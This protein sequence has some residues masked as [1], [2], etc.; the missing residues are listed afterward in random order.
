MAE[1]ILIDFQV[2][3]E[4][5][6]STIDLLERTGQIDAKLAS[7]FK[8]STAEFNKQSATIKAVGANL[9]ASKKGLEDVAKASK[10]LSATFAQGFQEGVIDTL[11]EAGVSVEQFN[12]AIQDGGAKTKA[13]TGTVKQE[14]RELTEQI[15]RA[16]ANGQD[17]GAQYDELV[18]KAG[19]LR[20]AIGDVNQE[21]RNTASDTSTFDGLISGA[22]GVAGGFAIAQGATALFGDESEE[23][24]QTL[25]KVN[26]VMAILQGLQSVQNVLQKESALN[27]LLNNK[28]AIVANAQLALENGLQSKNIVVKGLATVAQKAL[29]AAMAA[30][31]I[32]IVVVALAGLI[33]MLDSYA[34]N[35][36]E[37][38]EETARLNA[39][40]ASSGDNLDAELAGMKRNSDRRISDLKAQGAR[41]SEVIK[42]QINNEKLANEARRREIQNL[43]NVRNNLRNAEPE[44]VEKIEAQITKLEQ[45]EL[46]Y[47][48][49]QYIKSNELRQK[50][51][52]ED[53][54]SEEKA[55]EDAIKAMQKVREARD[56]ILR[57]EIAAI[58]RK[59]LTVEEGSRAELTLQ[60]RL[61]AA[62]ADLDL[63]AEK[64]TQNEILLIKEKSLDDQLKLS[65]EYNAKI[66][67]EAI[68]NE[69]SRN[70]AV[71]E[72]KKTSD[73][74]RLILT[75]ANI[76]FTADLEVEA[77][78]GNEA[79][80]KEIYARRDSAIADLKKKFIDDALN[81]ELARTE[82]QQGSIRRGLERIADD[83]KK[84]V[85][86]RTSA[87]NQLAEI[88]VAGVDKQLAA[89]EKSYAQRLIADKDYELQRD[90]LLDKRL[91]AN[92]KAEKRITD[93]NAEENEKRKQKNKEAIEQIL[94]VAQEVGSILQGLS[95]LQTAQ[96][97]S[98]IDKEKQA[99]EE[100]REAGA[101]TEKEAITRA[102]RI[103]AEER[104]IKTEA[105]RREKNLSI[106]NAVINGAGAV[107]KA[108]ATG[109]P[110]LAAIV[111]A[112]AAAQIAIIA[113]RPIP[114][115]GKGKRNKYQGLAEVGETGTEL[116]ERNGKMYVADKRTIM[117]LQK[118]DVVYN[119]KET[120]AM[121]S[122][123]T[124]RV[125]K[126][127]MVTS[128]KSSAVTFDY[129]KLGKSIAKNSKGVH[130]E[131]TKDFVSESVADGL[132]RVN[133]FNNRY[134]FR[135]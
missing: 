42:E 103:E 9:S 96:A 108:L 135:R 33:V 10:S 116:I 15:A 22:Q 44:E 51:R 101:I 118:D 102:K 74:D 23:L 125:D 24:Q 17:Y 133:Y 61:I 35:A 41:E 38:A 130:I 36:R 70:N 21:I 11:K 32:G 119:P 92:E 117:Y 25:L 1:T 62:K 20:D 31:P 57:N 82:A 83:S 65:K 72:R 99:L 132:S 79:K 123:P 91:E 48:T 39:A 59:L 14:L 94:S 114:K 66:S 100:A 43:Y 97:Q 95:D 76:A 64:L 56:A 106:F 67:R 26:A 109:G 126:Q 129:N 78:Q 84:S 50:V 86:D 53:K 60:R 71:I 111:G 87:I 75:I 3:D 93:I 128:S 104:R 98:K 80:I 54:E 69:I 110:I 18:Q 34:N 5:L 121:L 12:Q 45:D 16:K 58:E 49:Q 105:A 63:N 8:Q 28:L 6:N 30:N 73:E 4:Q 13:A 7:Q 90:Q 2:N 107:V 40:L 19:K 89:L 113:A 81:Y 120:Q 124:H 47:R 77:A 127:I 37:A 46:D 134:S 115:F 85:A 52:E 27:Q 55:K 112:L 88:E 131:F 29:N 68:Q 122:K